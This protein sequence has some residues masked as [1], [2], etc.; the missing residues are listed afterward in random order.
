MRQALFC[1]VIA[2]LIASH[3]AGAQDDKRGPTPEETLR[4][5]GINLDPPALIKALSNAEPVVRENAAIVLGHR[6][7]RS[8]VPYLK[9]ALR[10]SYS[11][12]RLAAAGALLEMG[13]KSAVAE[14]RN[15]LLQNK[16][17]PAAMKAAEILAVNGIDEGLPVVVQVATTATE[18]V[19]RVQ[20]VRKFSAFARFETQKPLIAKELSNVLRNDSDAIVRRAA[21]SEL[22]DVRSPEVVQAFRQAATD[23][24]AVVRGLAERYLKNVRQQ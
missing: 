23:S 24:D 4:A 8:A 15:T 10:D 16:D 19:D 6:K 11:Y 5:Y 20:A 2:V 22:Q 13:D 14:L 9:E 21:A 3:A 18:A 7:E 1:V 17:Y 12:G